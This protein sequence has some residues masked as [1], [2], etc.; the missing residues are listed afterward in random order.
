MSS[1]AIWNRYMQAYDVLTRVDGY[2]SNLMDIA[3][4]LKPAPGQQVFDAGSGTGN[5]S[6]ILAEL[7]CR[8]VAGDFSPS[9]LKGHRQKDAKANVVRLSLEDGLPFPGASF[10]AICCAS[11]LFALTKR[12]CENALREF[13]RIL[14]PGGTMVVTLPSVGSRNA[15]LLKMHF[16]GQIKKNG[17]LA[18]VCKGMCD[19][20]GLMKVL[21]YNWQLRKLPDWQGFH[22]FDEPEIRSMLGAAGFGTLELQRTYGNNFFLVRAWKGAQ[23]NAGP[24]CHVAVA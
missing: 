6:C 21:Y 4:A 12:G 2:R 8:V 15:N 18:G 16:R 5:L 1:F 10:D 20:P 11:V 7:G 19:T 23:E 22:L 14:R 13:H 3:Q 9:A 24:V 17:A